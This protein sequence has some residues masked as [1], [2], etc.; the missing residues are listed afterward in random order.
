ME[1]WFKS[2]TW[3]LYCILDPKFY[4]VEK[5]VESCFWLS[6]K[7]MK[8]RNLWQ[9]NVINWHKLFFSAAPRT[10]VSHLNCSNEKW[11]KICKDSP[12]FPAWFMAPGGK[13]FIFLS[14]E[15]SLKYFIKIVFLARSSILLWLT[16]FPIIAP[17]YY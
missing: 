1:T 14:I 16:P 15:V 5:K 10:F 4:L 12:Q 9:H 13:V 7:S 3:V 11:P 8:Q 2:Q 6:T 17:L